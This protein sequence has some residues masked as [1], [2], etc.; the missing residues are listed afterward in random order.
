MPKFFTSTHHVANVNSNFKLGERLMYYRITTFSYDP[1]REKDV[2]NWLN[3]ARAEMQSLPGVQYGR[4]VR[5]ASG[6]SMMIGAYDTKQS[7]DDARNKVTGSTLQGLHWE[8]KSDHCP[9]LGNVTWI[10]GNASHNT[11]H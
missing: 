10:N 9:G 8:I 5:I 7:A 3:S 2:I 1:E 4:G 6:Q 11:P